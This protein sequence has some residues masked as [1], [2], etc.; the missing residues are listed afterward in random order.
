MPSHQRQA[1]SDNSA[2]VGTNDG[3]NSVVEGE[4]QNYYDEIT[5]I[6][7]KFVGQQICGNP[8]DVCRYMRFVCKYVKVQF[9]KKKSCY[10]KS[11]EM[12][13]SF[14]NVE[15]FNK[16]YGISG[17]PNNHFLQEVFN[18]F[19]SEEQDAFTLLQLAYE[20]HN[21]GTSAQEEEHGQGFLDPDGFRFHPFYSMSGLAS[22]GMLSKQQY[23]EMAAKLM[24]QRADTDSIRLSACGDTAGIQVSDAAG[25]VMVQCWLEDGK[26]SGIVAVLHTPSE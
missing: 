17:N 13:K 20:K 14:I 21:A 24:G 2:V 8:E 18:E 1:I 26:V 4:T 16:Q 22:N 6:Y 12:V 9:Q 19:N 11:W 10:E 25:A 5:K 23:L 15:D 7:A 3:P